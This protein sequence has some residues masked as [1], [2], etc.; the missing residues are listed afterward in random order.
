MTSIQGKSAPTAATVEG[1]GETIYGNDTTTAQRIQALDNELHLLSPGIDGDVII[2]DYIYNHFLDFCSGDAAI[3]PTDKTI[4][5]IKTMADYADKAYLRGRWGMPCI[6]IDNTDEQIEYGSIRR[7]A[8]ILFRDI[9]MSAYRQGS[10]K[11]PYDY[12]RSMS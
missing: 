1:T 7:E 10:A 11:L 4:L 5:F 6:D 3:V 2:Y 12:Y 9:I 8:F